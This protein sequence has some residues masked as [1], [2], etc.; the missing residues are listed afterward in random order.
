MM[1]GGTRYASSQPSSSVFFDF[2]D[3]F[4]MKRETTLNETE[5][6]PKPFVTLL[7]VSSAARGCTAYQIEAWQLGRKVADHRR[8][9]VRGRDNAPRLGDADNAI[10][11]P[12]PAEH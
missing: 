6:T 11:L 12:R 1:L 3:L 7:A 5:A 10:D 2:L 4:V 9:A 8:P